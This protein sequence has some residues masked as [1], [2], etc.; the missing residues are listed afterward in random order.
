MYVILFKSTPKVET[1]V[2]LSKAPSKVKEFNL[3]PFWLIDYSDFLNILALLLPDN[4]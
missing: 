4:P 3:I 1:I 2:I